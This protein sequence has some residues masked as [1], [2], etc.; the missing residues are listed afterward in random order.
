MNQFLR[1]IRQKFLSEGNTGKFLKYAIGEIILVVI[2]ILIALEVNNLNDLRKSNQQE[3]LLI[4]ALKT[5]LKMDITMLDRQLNILREDSTQNIGLVQKMSDSNVT[6]ETLKQIARYEFEPKLPVTFTFNDNT[7]QSLLSTGSLNIMDRWILEDILSLNEIHKTYISRTNLNL[8]AYV[9]Q[10]TAFARNYPL[11]DY[12]NINP[13]SKLADAIWKKAVFEELGLSLNSIISIRNVTNS[14]A[15]EQIN[16]ILKKTK[17][18]LLRLD[19]LK[20]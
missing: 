13:D 4:E 15:L 8:T 3:N 16:E 1:K 17:A 5:D 7:I 10:L 20:N 2:G 9:N 18:M 14:Y 6:I 19:R 11:R 12:G